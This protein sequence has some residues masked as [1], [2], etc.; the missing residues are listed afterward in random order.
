MIYLEDENI[1]I[2]L[3]LIRGNKTMKQIV[4]AMTGDVKAGNKDTILRS[5]AIGSCIVI[6]AYDKLNQTAAMAHIMLP[7]KAPENREVRKTKY[8][9]DAIDELASLLKL[10]RA[11]ENDIEVCIAGGANVLK[12]NDDDIGLDIIQ[13]VVVLLKKRKI[14]IVAKSLGGTKRRSV[15]L[16]VETGC[17]HFTVGDGAETLLWKF[18]V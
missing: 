18:N 14:K 15:S 16:D 7:G 17:L 12:R 5:G 2:K 6:V 9:N 11:N 3:N 13:S 8:A 4:Y 10:N 1:I